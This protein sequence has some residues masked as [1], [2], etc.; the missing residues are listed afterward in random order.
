MDQR[1]K[2]MVHDIQS[3][4]GLDDYYLQR[5]RLDDRVNMFNETMYVL[6]MEWF[7]NHAA[8]RTEEELNPDGAAVIEID[9]HS[10][11]LDHIIFV[12]DVSYAQGISFHSPALNEVIDWV[13]RESGLIHETDFQLDKMDD[14]MFRFIASHNGIP[15]YP[16]GSI[17]VKIDAKGNLTHYS[18]LGYFPRED[19]YQEEEYT[20][21]FEKIEDSI[22]EQI[23]LVEWPNYEQEQMDA[24]YGLQEIFIKNNQTETIPYE[25]VELPSKHV[26]IDKEMKSSSQTDQPFEKQEIEWM[27]EVDIEA[28]FANEPSPDVQTITEEDIQT[29]EENVQAF[30]NHVYAN[31]ESEWVLTM[32]YRERGYIHAIL[33]TSQESKRPFKRKV[34]VFIDPE[35]LEVLNYMDNQL[36][37]KAMDSFQAPK[38][39]EISPDEAYQKLKSHIELDAYYVYDDQTETYVLCGKIDCHYAVDAHTGVLIDM[40][41]L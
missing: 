22:Q 19:Q 3:R 17:E 9:L 36:M 14:H 26:R 34:V 28:A 23:K 27:N 24:L 30:I 41:E 32:L 29:C 25:A 18:K 35:T 5:Y 40:N 31:D 16:T 1:I 6:G 4:F 8:E 2:E 38:S 37:V 15:V 10:K 13:E 20:L 33:N 21:S 12:G 7:P 39:I 11:Q